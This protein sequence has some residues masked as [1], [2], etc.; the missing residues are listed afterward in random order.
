MNHLHCFKL[1]CQKR[2]LK[3][4]RAYVWRLND[5]LYSNNQWETFLKIHTH[6]HWLCCGERG[7]PARPSAH[8]HS[9][10]NGKGRWTLNVFPALKDDSHN[11]DQAVAK[12]RLLPMHSQNKH[13]MLNLPTRMAW[14]KLS[15][16]FVGQVSKF[17]QADQFTVNSNDVDYCYY[18]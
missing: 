15:G 9:K 10:L 1:L 11:L 8:P 4:P 14:Y 3:L 16:C 12:K 6:T 17:L 5:L 18:S 2:N 7:S 13:L